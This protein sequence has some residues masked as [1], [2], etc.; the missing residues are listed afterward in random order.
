M[1]NAPPRLQVWLPE[2]TAEQKAKLGLPDSDSPLEARWIN[3]EGRGGQQAYADGLREKD[4]VIAL[5]GEPIRNMNSPQFSAHIKLHYQVGDVL[6]L[7]VLRA[8]KKLELQIKLV[9]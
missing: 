2:L 8:G 7:T 6:P 5:A 3:R 4:V 1:W 9:E